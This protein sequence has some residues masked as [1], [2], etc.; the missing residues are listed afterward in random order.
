[1]EQWL[2]YEA[3][4]TTSSIVFGVMGAWIAVIYPGTLADILSSDKKAKQKVIKLFLP[5]TISV[6]ILSSVLL[7]GITAPMLKQID[8]LV[9]HKFLVRRISYAFLGMI[10]S[11]QFWALLILLLPPEMIEEHLSKIETKEE[12][13]RDLERKED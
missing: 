6:L 11:I 2:L 3:L 12:V 9:I 10:T 5:M 7:I 1:M 4:R 8:F 13:T